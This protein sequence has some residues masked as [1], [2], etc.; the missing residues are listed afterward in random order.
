MPIYN[1]KSSQSHVQQGRPINVHKLGH[2]D[3]DELY[4]IVTP[5]KHWEIVVVSAESA[6]RE[7]FPACS[8]ANGHLTNRA[9]V[10]V[11]LEGLT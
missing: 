5:E 6:T 4:K 2:I 7:V 8:K 10:I 9:L 1:S 11:D 3:L